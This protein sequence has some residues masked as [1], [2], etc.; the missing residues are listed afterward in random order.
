[1]AVKAVLFDMDG[2]VMD[3]E[4]SCFEVEKDVLAR[5]G[6]EM[7]VEQY[8]Q[9]TGKRGDEIRK[10]QESFFP[11]LD[12]ER[13]QKD[14]MDEFIPRVIEVPQRVKPGFHELI[15]ELD[16]R[17]IKKYIVTSTRY[18]MT[19]KKLTLSGI[20]DCFDEIITG[21]MVKRSKPA[22]DM[23]LHA[24]EKCGFPKEECLV[25]EDSIAGVGAA[26]NAEIACICVP[27]LCVPPEELTSKCLA[28]VD[29]LADV[30]PYLD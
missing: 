3:S 9:L 18:E 1:M 27:D 5:Q 21:E 28:V 4:T 11:G 30:I 19:M 10:V 15:A 25:L 16:K 26:I 14:F 17:G 8:V 12:F 24:Q 23:Y 13:Y 29:T 22:P 20:L 6:Y 7:T 2:L